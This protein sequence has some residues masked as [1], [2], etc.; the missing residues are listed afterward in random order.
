MY[1]LDRDINSILDDLDNYEDKE[2]I[3]KHIERIDRLL[4][5]YH[6]L[7]LCGIQTISVDVQFLRYVNSLLFDKYFDMI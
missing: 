7:Q 5:E 4:E 3:R 2:T 6:R 1:R